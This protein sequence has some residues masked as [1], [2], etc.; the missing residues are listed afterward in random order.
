VLTLQLAETCPQPAC[1]GL[2]PREVRIKLLPETE[3]AGLKI[4]QFALLHGVT[5]EI[6]KADIV[7]TV[8]AMTKGESEGTE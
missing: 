8:A 1:C 6:V 3:L 7:G 4:T 2:E 5:S